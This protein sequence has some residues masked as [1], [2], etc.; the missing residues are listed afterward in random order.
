MIHDLSPPLS[1]AIHVWPGDTP[2]SRQVLC[3]VEEG[4]SVTLSTLLTTVHVGSHADGPVHY[5]AGAPGVGELDLSAFLGECVLIDAPVPRGSRVRPVDLVGGLAAVTAPRVLIRTGTFPDALNWNADFAGLAP[6]LVEALA[7]LGV[8]TVGVDTPSVDLQDSKDLPA[9]KAFLRRGVYILEG[10]V[11]RDIPPGR[12]ELIA[13]PLR[14]MG[15]DA[16][17]VRAVLRSL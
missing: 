5:G 2:L 17:P 11:M 6:E 16:S 9:H 13:L 7:D 1:P 10:L 15:F 3:R 14:L 8:L 4:A 12:Y